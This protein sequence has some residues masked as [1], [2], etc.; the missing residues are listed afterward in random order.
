[1][2][3]Y[4]WRDDEHYPETPE[5]VRYRDE[6]LTREIDGELPGAPPGD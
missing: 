4:P 3:G 6:W 5:L 1:M 2:S